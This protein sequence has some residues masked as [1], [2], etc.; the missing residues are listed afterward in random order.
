MTIENLVKRFLED[1]KLTLRNSLAYAGLGLSKSSGE[2][3]EV[4][5]DIAFNG[6]A[7]TDERKDQVSDA[8]GDLMFYVHILAQ[9]CDISL[10][11][12]VRRFINYFLIKNNQQV[13]TE[14]TV[15]LTELMRHAKRKLNKKSQW[16][17]DKEKTNGV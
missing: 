10:E 12:I 5:T 3:N 11:D 4:V 14:T 9:Q 13:E 1:E 6:H 17:L 2:I 7:F 8:L 16:Q 15:S